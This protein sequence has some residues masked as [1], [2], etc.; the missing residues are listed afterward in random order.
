MS[1]FNYNKL[2]RDYK[3]EVQSTQTALNNALSD[4]TYQKKNLALIEDLYKIDTE[5][6]I[7]GAIKQSDLTSTYY[8]LQQTQT[9]YLNSVYNYLVAVVRYKKASG[10]L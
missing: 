3:Q 1:K 6:L 2:S 4:L 8:T 9:N 7:N 5:R 10:I